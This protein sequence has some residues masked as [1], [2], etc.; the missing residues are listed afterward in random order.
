M[1]FEKALRKLFPHGHPR[2]VALTLEEL[3]LHNVKNY[4]FAA[5]GDPIGNFNRVST[6]KS[7]YPGFD[8]E[9]PF[10]TCID[11]FLKQFDSM[12][13]MRCKGIIAKVEGIPKRLMDMIVYSKIAIC[14]F[15]E[16]VSKNGEKTL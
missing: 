9:S 5:G 2:Y 6:I 8:W 15:Y 11:Y 10:G 4:D 16:E 7:L 1:E 3:E 13:W 14:I 12:M